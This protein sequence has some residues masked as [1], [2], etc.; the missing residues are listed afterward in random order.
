MRVAALIP[1][2]LLASA[3]P[4]PAPTS[5]A[6]DDARAIV[7]RIVL[8]GDEFG[9]RGAT[10]APDLTGDCNQLLRMDPERVFGALRE[11]L[12][13][14]RD[15][16][17]EASQHRDTI[18]SL[19]ALL[20]GRERELSPPH[21]Q[22][23]LF[24]RNGFVLMEKRRPDRTWS[25]ADW[26]PAP[27][28][29]QVCGKPPKLRAALEPDGPALLDWLLTVP[30]RD[31]DTMLT[32]SFVWSVGVGLGVR[33]R[34]DPALA[35]RLTA[36]VAAMTPGAPPRT[37]AGFS[38]LCVSLWAGS[39]HRRP[40]TS[41]G[42]NCSRYPPYRVNTTGDSTTFGSPMPSGTAGETRRS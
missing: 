1:V 30:D 8:A 38:G 20:S 9:L 37:R 34:K 31:D 15:F 24:S 23:V 26:P 16:Q 10:A 28:L 14:S 17:N 29:E 6:G 2:L 22:D 19:A 5:G 35:K 32:D 3:C 7:E 13:L 40:A 33:A 42:R 25:G 41:S 39:A 27:S 36:Q 21:P 18:E 12:D 11:A 4:G